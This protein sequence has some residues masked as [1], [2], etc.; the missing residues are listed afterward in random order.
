[1]KSNFNQLLNKGKFD[2]FGKLFNSTLV[3]Q[4]LKN[5]TDK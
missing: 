3:F 1:M 4:C 5:F 2:F